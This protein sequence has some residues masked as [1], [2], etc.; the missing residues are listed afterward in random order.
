MT[1]IDDHSWNAA[2][3]EADKLLGNLGH[4]LSNESVTSHRALLS[5]KRTSTPTDAEIIAD[6]LEACYRVSYNMKQ[7]M[8]VLGNHYLWPTCIR[9]L[10]AAIA[11][12]RGTE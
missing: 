10:D 12:A 4:W 8:R 11:K 5:L 3:D 6:L 1:T 7:E 2:I 9:I